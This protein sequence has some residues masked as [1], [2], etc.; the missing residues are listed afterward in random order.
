ML[1]IITTSNDLLLPKFQRN[2]I[3]FVNYNSLLL[4]K[5]ILGFCNLK[6]LKY[7]HNHHSAIYNIYIKIPGK[8][9]KLL[10]NVFNM[11]IKELELELIES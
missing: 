3:K 4:L 8:V 9:L 7:I 11:Y 2:F 6:R 10:K 5:L 1:L